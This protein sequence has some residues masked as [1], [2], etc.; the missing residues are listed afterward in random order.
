[1]EI[2]CCRS[3]REAL[4]MRFLDNIPRV[5]IGEALGSHRS[6]GNAIL[7]CKP[8]QMRNCASVSGR[9]IEKALAS[10]ETAEREDTNNP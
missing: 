1:M 3:A 10:T 7:K 6:R 4:Q 9:P 5:E 8:C 2:G